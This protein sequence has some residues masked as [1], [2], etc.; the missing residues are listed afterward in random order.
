MMMMTTMV[1][2]SFNCDNNMMDDDFLL[3]APPCFAFVHDNVDYFPCMY[4]LYNMK[5]LS[6][7]MR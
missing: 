1:V 7:E 3:A 5:N 2:C 6:Q 4:I